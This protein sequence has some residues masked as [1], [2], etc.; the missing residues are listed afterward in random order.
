MLDQFVVF[1]FVWA[2]SL[3]SQY[4]NLGWLSAQNYI[5]GNNNI[6]NSFN[7]YKIITEADSPVSLLSALSDRVNP[8]PAKMI[9]ANKENVDVKGEN[10][11]YQNYLHYFKK[12][13]FMED[14]D[15]N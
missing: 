10:D 2:Y 1:A 14:Q 15:D 11:I 9:L 6:T 4:Y 3:R 8:L 7:I 5:M 13:K 12:N